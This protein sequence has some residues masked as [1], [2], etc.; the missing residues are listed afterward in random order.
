MSA[1]G[2]AM[3]RG[4]ALTSNKEAPANET[5]FTKRN[6]VTDHPRNYVEAYKNMEVINEMVD[7]GIVWEDV[8]TSMPQVRSISFQNEYH[9][10][11]LGKQIAKSTY[12]S[13]G[14]I[15]EFN[16]IIPKGLYTV[17][18][19]FELVLPVRFKDENGNKF[20]LGQWLLV[21]NCFGHLIENIS[22]YRKE[23]QEP[24]LQPGSS[25]SV[26]R[27][28]Q[29]MLRHM[30]EK[31]LQ[32]IEMDLF[33]TKTPV[34]GPDAHYRYNQIDVFNQYEHL[35][36]SRNKFAHVIADQHFYNPVN[37]IDRDNLIWRDNKYLILMRLLSR[38][39]AIASQVSVDMT[40]RFNIE[41]DVK[42]LFENIHRRPPA[43]KAIF[44]EVPKIN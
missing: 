4:N 1:G 19:D 37:N 36:N 15:P 3:V 43:L 35:V 26:A 12:I 7:L 33:Y 41:Q 30:T 44:Y 29:D 39:F 34:V 2:G 27:Y 18:T 8:L 42:K 17:P 5:S 16:I 9:Q 40:I 10:I 11:T 6:E 22:V 14:T 21:N 38:F 25:G 31:Q 20:N 23:E 13:S 24:M 28:S 32:F